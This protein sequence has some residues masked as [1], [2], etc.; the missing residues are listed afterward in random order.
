MKS[1]LLVSLLSACSGSSTQLFRANDLS[2]AIQPPSMN[3]QSTAPDLA[4]SVVKLSGPIVELE[5]LIATLAAHPDDTPAQLIAASCIPDASVYAEYADG[6]KSSVVTSGGDCNFVLPVKRNT[7]LH[8]VAG[9]NDAVCPL[10]YDA[11]ALVTGTSD[12]TVP[13]AS[14]LAQNAS[15]AVAG[16]AGAL[17]VPVTDV[18]AEGSCVVL[19][20]DGSTS[21]APTLVASTLSVSGSGAAQLFAMTNA[22]TE[23]PTFEPMNA[24]P[25]GIYGIVIP[26]ST[27]EVT[28]TVQ[29]TGSITPAMHTYTPATCALR[30]GLAT[31]VTL[32]PTN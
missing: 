18:L 16:I 9:H 21:L 2:T 15:A 10:T 14:A 7:T 30:P 29:A 1:V 17:A 32:S 19:V 6:T 3:D 25:L 31:L 12:L 13:Y 22:Q 8:L 24:S 11:S 23:P 5:L 4:D 26:G 28:T 20:D 27:T